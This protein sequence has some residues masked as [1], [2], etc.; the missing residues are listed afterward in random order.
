[1]KEPAP[2]PSQYPAQGPQPLLQVMLDAQVDPRFAAE[3][4]LD[5][6]R[7]VIERALAAEGRHAV[8]EIS[9]VIADDAT[10]RQLNVNYRGIDRPTD[11]LSFPLQAPEEIPGPGQTF[12]GPP[13]EVLRLGDVVV[14][15]QRAQE[16]AADYGHS[17]ARELAYLTVHGVLHLL[18]YDHE[19]EAD[20]RVM[21]NKEEAALCDEQGTARAGS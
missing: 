16:Q 1:M 4:D 6:L 11:V 12:I 20:R 19:D 3:V 14:S 8:V 15:F 18:G 10:L 9:L 7:R 17:L 13:D 5:Q 21:R 2:E